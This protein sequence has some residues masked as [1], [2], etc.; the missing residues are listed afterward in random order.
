MTFEVANPA[1]QSDS[2]LLTQLVDTECV[3]GRR[4]YSRSKRLAAY[5]LARHRRLKEHAGAGRQQLWRHLPRSESSAEIGHRSPSHAPA[6]DPNDVLLR[7][8]QFLPTL[9]CH[10]HFWRYST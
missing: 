5:L 6:L 2:L 9:G 7:F 8:L 3:A 4:G 10:T 1:I